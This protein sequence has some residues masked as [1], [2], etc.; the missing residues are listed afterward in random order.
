LDYRFTAPVLKL[1]N[2]FFCYVLSSVNYELYKEVPVE[3][4]YSPNK[5]PI[6]CAYGVLRTS[7]GEVIVVQDRKDIGSKR[8]KFPGGKIKLEK[9]G[10]PLE[11]PEQALVREL[12]EEIT[13]IRPITLADML[14]K[15]KPH[16]AHAMAFYFIAEPVSLEE[17]APGRKVQAIHALTHAELQR[18]MP[19]M[20]DAHGE[21]AST[22]TFPVS[23]E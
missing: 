12:K 13:L 5:L 16:Q 9:D 21:I 1:T 19:W 11:T 22:L 4:I 18:E 23:A 17:L 7:S 3:F 8:K 6:L 15:E 10:A 14:V 20:L 2:Y